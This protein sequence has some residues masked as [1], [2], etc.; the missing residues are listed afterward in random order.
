MAAG[1]AAAD[2]DFP[3]IDS[4]LGG[5]GAEVADGRAGVLHAIK[6]R[7]GA[8]FVEAVLHAD[9]DHAVAFCEIGGK[10]IHPAWVHAAP[11]PAVDEVETGAFVGGGPALGEEQAELQFSID[12][13]FIN[14]DLVRGETGQA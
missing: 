6:D 11:A 2:E 10:G 4:Q 12:D 8:G 7:R 14:H 3:R 5:V 13:F 1:R 9:P